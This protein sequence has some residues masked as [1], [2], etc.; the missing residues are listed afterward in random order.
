LKRYVRE[1]GTDRALVLTRRHFILSAAI[2]PLEMRSAL[3]RLQ[4][5]GA[6]SMKAFHATVRRIQMERD[7]WDLV[8]IST[9]VLN[10]AERLTVDLNI[11]SLDAIHLACGLACQSRLRHSV[12][13]ITADARQRDAASELG[14]EIISV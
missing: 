8:M 13:F 11:R 1:E 6:L 10:N 12:P 4:A 5:E 9:D 14:L 2:A 3:R 7:K